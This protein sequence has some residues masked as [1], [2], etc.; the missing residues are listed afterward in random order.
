[1]DNIGSERTYIH[2]KRSEMH[3]LQHFRCDDAATLSKEHKRE[4][5]QIIRNV[6]IYFI[7]I[8]FCFV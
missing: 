8:F 5:F 2:C 7:K 3:V 4:L 6:R 1:M